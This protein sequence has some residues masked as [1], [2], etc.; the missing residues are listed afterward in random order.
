MGRIS[1]S[2]VEKAALAWLAGLGYAVLH[3]PSAGVR[4][5][6]SCYGLPRLT[7]SRT[8]TGAGSISD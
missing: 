4:E 1:E 5:D 3:G 2:E 7:M 8:A 6:P